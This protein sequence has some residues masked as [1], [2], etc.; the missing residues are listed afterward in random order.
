MQE[1]FSSLVVIIPPPSFRP[2]MV[3]KKQ[4]FPFSLKKQAHQRRARPPLAPL[5]LQALQD[6]RAA[7]V[8]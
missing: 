6:K 2:D 3:A 1:R 4:P 5:V 7:G 8:V